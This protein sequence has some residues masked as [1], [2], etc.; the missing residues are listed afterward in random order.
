MASQAFIDGINSKANE[1]IALAQLQRDNEASLQAQAVQA[2][3]DA[4]ATEDL[5]DEYSA[6]LDSL[7]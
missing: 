5:R 2:G 3:H 7:I 6:L 1:L 4:Q